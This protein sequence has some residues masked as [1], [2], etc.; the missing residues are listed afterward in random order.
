MGFLTNDKLVIVGAGGAIGSTM[1]QLALTMK[2]TPNV[3]LYDVYAPGMEGVMEEM[4]HCGYDGVNL[5]A[6]T[7]VAEAF[8]DA[9]YIIQTHIRCQ[10]HR[11]RQLHHRRTDSTTSTYNHKFVIS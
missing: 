11:E 6:T 10:L 7:D 3:C 8:K 2:L 5:T 4:F 9:K 1:V